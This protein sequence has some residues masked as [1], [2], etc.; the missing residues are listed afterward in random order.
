MLSQCFSQAILMMKWIAFCM[1]P[2]GTVCPADQRSPSRVRKTR[3]RCSVSDQYAYAR[4][5]K[6]FLMALM[7]MVAGSLSLLDDAPPEDAAAAPGDP[8]SVCSDLARAALKFLALSVFRCWTLLCSS[9]HQRMD[10]K[11]VRVFGNDDWKGVATPE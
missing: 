11:W 5:G 2:A 9:R 6:N 8:V 3:K 7:S 1:S 10:L 4:G